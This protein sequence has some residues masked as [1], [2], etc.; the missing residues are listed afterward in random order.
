[1]LVRLM[2]SAFMLVSLVGLAYAD[3]PDCSESVVLGLELTGELLAPAGVSNQIEQDLAAIRSMYP[4]VADIVATESWV[5]GSIWVGLDSVAR[6]EYSAG[7]YAALDSINSIYGATEVT[8]FSLT[9]ALLIDFL[10]C[11]HPVVL[12]AIYEELD[13]VVYA[14]VNP[15]YGG[16]GYDISCSEL[17][18]YLFERTLPDYTKAYWEFQVSDGVATLLPSPVDETE[19]VSALLLEQNTPNP[20]NPSTTIGFTVGSPGNVQLRILDIKGRVVRRILSRFFE[21]GRYDAEWNGR[22]SQGERVASGVYFSVLEQSG[23]V[24]TRKMVV[25][26]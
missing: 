8:S 25:L 5:P 24:L 12:G 4:S 16:P 2:T 3:S 9:R 20:F 14:E 6:A 22:D 23:E 10:E 17:G 26:E 15:V 7:T 18:L 1:M 21:S 19:F 11:Y 13:G